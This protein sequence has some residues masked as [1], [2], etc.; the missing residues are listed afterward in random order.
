MQYVTFLR[1]PTASS[2]SERYNNIRIT[3]EPTT[4]KVV[5]DTIVV[6]DQPNDDDDDD[7]DDD[8]GIITHK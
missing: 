5:V 6:T 4:K 2:W 3:S 7:D 8:D 1:L